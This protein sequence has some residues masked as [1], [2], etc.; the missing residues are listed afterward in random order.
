M[1]KG[2]GRVVPPDFEHYEKYPLAA[3][4]DSLTPGAVPVQLA[5]NWYTA[6]D[7]PVRYPSGRYWIA[8][9]GNLGTNRGGHDLCIEPGDAQD[10]DSW[11]DFYNQKNWPACVGFGCARGQSILNRKR[12]NGLT[13]YQFA[14]D[15]DGLPDAWEGTTLRAGLETMRSQGLQ[16][17]RGSVTGSWRPG[18]GVAAYRWISSVDELHRVLRHPL[19]DRLGAVC[20]LNS[21]GRDYPHRVWVEDAVI[22]R[23]LREDGELGVVTDR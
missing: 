10:Y 11:W 15:H 23:L 6:F 16:I 13:L 5:C 14:H 4:P 22:D 17:V 3:A 9:G 1:A 12:Y 8:R 19:A 21:W 20:L 7:H 2:L 18:E